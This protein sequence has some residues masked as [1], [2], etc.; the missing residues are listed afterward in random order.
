MPMKQQTI[1][2]LKVSGAEK[3]WTWELK[4]RDIRILPSSKG[5]LP[6][7]TYTTRDAA[8]RAALAAA[9]LLSISSII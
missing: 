4:G 3:R 2:E 8:R 7:R 1:F 6:E 9:K 5:N